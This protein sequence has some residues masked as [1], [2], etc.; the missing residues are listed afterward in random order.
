M[1]LPTKR[2]LPLSCLQLPAFRCG[3]KGHELCQPKR[4]I[5]RDR[6]RRL[7]EFLES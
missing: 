6:F 1:G 4:R 2:A 5:F 3:F 7:G